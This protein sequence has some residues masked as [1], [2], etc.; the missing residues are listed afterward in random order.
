MEKYHIPVMLFEALEYLKIRKDGVYVDCTLGGGGHSLEIA[1]SLSE[2]GVLISLDWDEDAL[3]YVEE[4]RRSKKY[5]CNWRL[6]KSN[7]VKLTDVLK[8]EGI[9]KVDGILFDLGVSSYQLD[10]AERGFSF[11]KQAELDM[12]MDR[13][14]TVKAKD[15]ING[16]YK[17]ELESL[18]RTYGEEPR[19]KKIAEVIVEK[20]EE[21]VIETTEQ[22]S[23]II[24]KVVPFK[25][26]NKSA[27]RVFQALR[28][29]VNDELSNLQTGLP[30]AL[31]SLAE[32]GRCVVMSF[33]SLEDRIVKN[34]FLDSEKKGLGKRLSKRPITPTPA[35]IIQNPRARS[36]KMRVFEKH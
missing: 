27:M 12:R 19:A 9:E 18:L 30:Q 22:L 24:Q 13:E 15:L 6:V 34:V 26:R 32:E 17:K 25:A 1:K 5:E 29:A 7:F 4:M 23:Q 14:L 36:A 11:K 16:L 33:H 20:R 28:I 35:E 3:K 2:K 8:Q 21:N 31:E 10:V